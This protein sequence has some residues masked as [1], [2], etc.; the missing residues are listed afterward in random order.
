M[1]SALFIIF[2]EVSFVK[3]QWWRF[4][5]T[6]MYSSSMEREFETQQTCTTAHLLIEGK[7]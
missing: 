7:G 6:E 4:S 2:C 5:N 3:G 1:A